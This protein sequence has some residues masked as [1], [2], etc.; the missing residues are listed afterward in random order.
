M[1]L[2]YTLWLSAVLIL[3]GCGDSPDEVKNK[4]RL[5]AERLLLERKIF[6]MELN[7]AIETQDK[8]V[9]ELDDQRMALCGGPAAPEDPPIRTAEEQKKL[10]ELTEKVR[11]LHNE[12][13]EA[14]ALSQ[15]LGVWTNLAQQ[16]YDDGN[17]DKALKMLK[18]KEFDRRFSFY[19]R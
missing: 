4:L 5:E 17:I 7:E 10:D 3:V 18:T 11:K 19:P 2:R 14:M 13:E 12:V 15:V 16:A 6:V 9:D 1:C 8:V